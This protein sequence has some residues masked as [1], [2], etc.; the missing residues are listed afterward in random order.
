MDNTGGSDDPWY[1]GTASDYPV[2]KLN[3]DFNDDDTVDEDDWKT[4]AT[5]LASVSTTGAKAINV[6]IVE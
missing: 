1:F 3:I 4:P 6:F 5:A 2:L